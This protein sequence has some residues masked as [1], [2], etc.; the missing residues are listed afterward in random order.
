MKFLLP[1]V[2]F[3]LICGLAALALPILAAPVKVE[4]IRTADGWQLKRDGKP[5]FVKGAGGTE[6]LDLLAAAGANSVRTWGGDNLTP[7]L[8]EAQ[9]NGLTVTVGIWLHHE[10]D[11]EQFSY[12]NPEMLKQQLDA[13]RQAILRYKDHPAVLMWGIGNEM[14]GYKDGGKAA[15][16]KNVNDAA[17]LAKELDPNHPVMTVIAEIGDQRI[18]SINQYCP[19]VD[20]VGINSYAGASS[21]ATRYAALNPQ[22]PYIITEFGPPGAWEGDK[23]SWAA[24]IEPTSPEKADWYRRAYVGSIDHKPWCV[25]SYA[26]LW[27]HKQESTATWFGMFLADGSKVNAVDTMTELWS[28]KLPKNLCPSIQHLKIDGAN[29]LKPGQTLKV[30][31]EASD[32]AG[33]PV[34]VRWVVQPEQIK[35][36]IGGQ[37][38]PVLPELQAVI[39]NSDAQHCEI[40]AP[41][42]EGGYRVFAYA[43]NGVGSSVANVPFHVHLVDEQVP[44]GKAATLP[45]YIYENGSSPKNHYIPS[46][47]MGKTAAIKMN[48][49]WVENPH[50]APSCMQIQFTADAD[51]GGIIWQDPADDWGD[52]DGGWNL[53]GAKKLVFWARGDQGGESVSFKFGVL[54]RDKNFFDSASGGLEGVTLTKEWKEYAIDLTNQNLARIKTGFGWSLAGQGHLVMFYLDDIRFE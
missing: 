47:W 32:P 43:N 54:G 31:L 12:D 10:G 13:V 34:K 39:A 37:E 41:K 22:K 50:S 14:E 2:K 45:F 44:P 4:L 1:A 20:I 28:G 17:K 52:R 16:W 42:N 15:I 7:L 23:T 27:G 51:W 36:G 9:K 25:G 49:G 3:V 18:P 21:I 6:R 38:E 29:D 33:R 11:T 53:T 30:N 24:P 8:D 35:T 46:G 5:F 26:F 19:D 40:T 48:L